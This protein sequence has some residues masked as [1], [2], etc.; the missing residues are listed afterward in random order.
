MP[1]ASGGE[2]ACLEIDDDKA[3]QL[4]VIEEEIEVEVLIANVQVNLPSD[5][6]KSRTQFEE[7]FL[8]VVDEAKFDGAFIGVVRERQK[9]EQVGIFG[10]LLREVGLRGWECG[11]EVGD[12]LALAMVQAAV[13]LPVR[14][15]A[16]EAYTR[17]TFCFLAY[18]SRIA[19]S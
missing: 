8:D 17:P 15:A 10:K 18:G 1:A 14:I 13:N 5:Q 9:V 11:R 4:Q 2:V 16:L 6:C 19:L 7:K 12:G 3:A